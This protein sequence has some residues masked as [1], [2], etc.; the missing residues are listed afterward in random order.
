MTEDELLEP[1]VKKQ[2]K[3]DTLGKPV[4]HEIFSDGQIMIT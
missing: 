3:D 1:T 2:R 4:N